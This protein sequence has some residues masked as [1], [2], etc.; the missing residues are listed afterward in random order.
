MSIPSENRL[1]LFLADAREGRPVL[2]EGLPAEASWRAPRPVTVGV[3]KLRRVGEG[4]NDLAAQGWAVIAPEGEAG[5]RSLEAI[6][7]LC[8]LREEE[9]GTPVTVYRA[10]AGMSAKQAAAWKARTFWPEGRHE[11]EVPL[12]TLLLGELDGLSI[13][14]QQVLAA[15]G[16]LAGRLHFAR[17]SGEPDLDAYAAYA[18]KIVRF[19]RAGAPE[20]K[21]DL[22][23]YASPDGSSAT[24]A[25]KVRLVDPGLAASRANAASGRLA[26]AEVR[27]VH[28]NRVRTLLAAGAGTRPS[29]LL[30][31][32][33]GLGA[34]P[35]GWD[36]VEE[37]RQMQGALL[38]T[39]DEVLDAERLRGQT[40]LP[41]GLWFVVACF[42]AGTPNTSAY[43]AWLTRLA[44]AGEY[45]GDVEAVKRSLSPTPFL[46]A[47]PQ[48]ALA[49]PQGPLAVIGHLDLAWTSSF[50]GVDDPTESR[51]SRL[52]APLEK[53]VS[54]S[55]AGV[56]LGALM[57]EYG[58]V[59]DELMCD[60][61]L[62]E[63]ALNDGR[64]SPVDPAG[65]AYRWMLRND[66]RGYVLL[67]DPAVRLPLTQGAR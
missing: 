27:E 29:V 2:A 36:S 35:G 40:F 31:V 20:A 61:Q 38:L 23:F 50:S 33:H 3:K 21:G 14:L 25:G 62:E 26:A 44:E 10:P 43:H 56:A 19:A 9:Q 45:A 63:D 18:D 58:K 13:D 1:D 51:T 28:A 37:R 6:A 48:A 7:P 67:G 66:L 54:G 64:P 42:G 17:A 11:H 41:G 16:T 39:R 53:L 30:S 52:L 47:L 12:Y 24:R 46:S 65:R 32:S 15:S 5:D 22:L 55:R 60:H 59:N 4:W 57:L 49:N 34:P 8:K